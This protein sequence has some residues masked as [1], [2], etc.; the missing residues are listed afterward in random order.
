MVDEGGVS[1]HGQRTGKDHHSRRGA[2]DLQTFTA[3]EIQASVEPLD[4]VV[5]VH[6]VI[7]AACS[8]CWGSEFPT[9]AARPA[10]TILN[11]AHFE[12]TFGLRLPAWMESLQ[13]ALGK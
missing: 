1:A 10:N 12:N 3:A 13:L 2:G 4:F 7:C 9:P 5:R 11:C 8:V 6:P